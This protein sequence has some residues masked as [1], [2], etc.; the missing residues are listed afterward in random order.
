MKAGEL[1]YS[2]YH[3]VDVCLSFE[4]EP[5]AWE[6]TPFQ[7]LNF[8]RNQSYGVFFT[9]NGYVQLTARDEFIYHDMIV[10]P[11]MAVNPDIRR[12]LIIGGGDGGTAREV[13]RYPQV[14]QI[15]LVEID[16]A[17]IRLSRQYLPQTAAVFDHEPRLKVWIGDG[18]EFVRKAKPD[19]YDLILV[20]STD[21]VGPGE[22]LFT[23]HFYQDCYRILSEQG[24]MINQQEGAF[25]DQDIWE[26]QRAHRKVKAVFPISRV[27]GFNMPT[28]ASGYWYFGFASKGLD[29]LANQQAERWQAL[30]IATKYYNSDV[31]GASFVLPN[32]VREILMTV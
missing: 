16:E 12:V 3:A 9:L 1:W 29:P 6:K 18:V 19:A 10:H 2:E 17:V 5:L 32:Y 14:E 21:P 7:Q 28:Y 26:M 8:Y 15:D 23:T 27:Y 20:D 31:H 22:G 13:A 30:G 24:I 25:F 4:A 11:A